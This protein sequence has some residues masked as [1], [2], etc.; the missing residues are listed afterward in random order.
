VTVA[1]EK[2]TDAVSN[3][4]PSHL[5]DAEREA[6]LAEVY[7]E[8]R[9][10]ARRLLRGRSSQMTMQATELVNDAAL[11]VMRLDRMSWRDRQHMF[12][13]CSRILRQT[14]VDAIRRRNR[15]KRRTLTI[16]VAAGNDMTAVDVIQLDQVLN[17]LAEISPELEQVVELRFFIGLTIEEVAAVLD[18]SESTVKRRWQTARLWLADALSHDDRFSEASD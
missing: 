11:R 8:L 17:R 10:A 14:M 9:S 18:L 5:P 13:T 6:L 12:A 3:T 1:V 16:T 7:N 15:V 4:M 2:M